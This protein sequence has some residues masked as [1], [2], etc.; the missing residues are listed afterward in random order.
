[1]MQ[2]DL[3]YGTT[4]PLFRMSCEW[5]VPYDLVLRYADFLVHGRGGTDLPTVL[6]LPLERRQAIAAQADVMLNAHARADVLHEQGRLQF[7][8]GRWQEIA[9]G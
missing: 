8:D 1:M 7:V 4:A 5:G 6:Q 2:A 9:H 3:G